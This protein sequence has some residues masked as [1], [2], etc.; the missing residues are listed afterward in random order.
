[1]HSG[2]PVG[3]GGDRAA[4]RTYVVDGDAAAIQTPV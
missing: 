2:I 1:M 4:A 3:I